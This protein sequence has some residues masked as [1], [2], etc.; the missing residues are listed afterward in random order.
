VFQRNQTHDR[1]RISTPVTTRPLELGLLLIGLNSVPEMAEE[2][3]RAEELGF[4]VV[5]LGDHLN[6]HVFPDLFAQ[7]PS[8]TN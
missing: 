4:D 2:A 8:G 1:E 3:R 6:S 5:L 7:Q